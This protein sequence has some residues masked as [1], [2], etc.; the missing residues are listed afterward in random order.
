MKKTLYCIMKC[1]DGVIVERGLTLA[2]ANDYIDQMYE[3]DWEFAEVLIIVKE[4]YC[5]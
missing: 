1:N 2:E 5:Y 3:E 4:Y